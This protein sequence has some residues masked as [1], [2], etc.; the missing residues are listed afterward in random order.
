MKEKKLKQ[1]RREDEVE[2]IPGNT[3]WETQKGVGD[4]NVKREQNEMA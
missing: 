4:W 3:C 1:R 2:S